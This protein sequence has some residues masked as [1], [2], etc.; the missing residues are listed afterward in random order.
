[1]KNLE[2]GNFAGCRICITSILGIQYHLDVS[3]VD[4]FLKKKELGSASCYTEVF[5]GFFFFYLY[6]QYQGRPWDIT[7]EL[8][9]P[10]G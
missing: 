3:Q 10:Q 6:L 8:G 9:A 7:L 2:N 5:E 1:M 4:H